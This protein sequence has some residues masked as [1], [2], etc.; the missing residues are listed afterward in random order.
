MFAIYIIC[1]QCNYSKYYYNLYDL[2]INADGDDSTVY[3]T[4][5][6]KLY[7][8]LLKIETY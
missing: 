5:Y 7:I 4:N 8:A 2:K 3:Q 1:V 6:L